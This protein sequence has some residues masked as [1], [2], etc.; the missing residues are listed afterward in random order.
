VGKRRWTAMSELIEVAKKDE[1]QSGSM[2][3]VTAGGHKLL[4]ARVNDT[5]YATN[6][7]CPHMGGNLS[8]GKLEGT[9]VTCPWH[10][11]QFD[12]SN[13]QVVTWVGKTGAIAEL[14]KAIKHE[15][16]LTT[17]KVVIQ[18][19]SVAVEI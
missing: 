2:K 4:L 7:H 5:Y 12:L 15:K 18:D 13:G 17:Y 19:D 8:K 3:E 10:A 9:I 16:P 14:S 11:S 6:V 1:L